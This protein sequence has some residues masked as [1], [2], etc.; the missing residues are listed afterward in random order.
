MF[1]NIIA[2]VF[3]Y[4]LYF[5]LFPF[6]LLSGY[7]DLQARHDLIKM[8]GLELLMHHV[9]PYSLP[10]SEPH[11]K[12]MINQPSCYSSLWR[13]A[14][15]RLRIIWHQVTL[16]S[17]LS[18]TFSNL[19][20]TVFLDQSNDQ[21]IP[22]SWI[23]WEFTKLTNDQP[24]DAQLIINHDPSAGYKPVNLF[25]TMTATYYDCHGKHLDNKDGQVIYGFQ[26]QRLVKRGY[27]QI[28]QVF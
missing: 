25:C 14:D 19:K 12:L 28:I 27:Q 24:R 9:I 23:R 6:L 15:G 16:Q 4:F 18:I 10:H 5:L 17:R 2:H 8:S 11:A 26:R 22:L 3:V 1:S 21:V 13:D 7:Q 20:G